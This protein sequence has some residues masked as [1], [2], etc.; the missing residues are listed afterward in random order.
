MTVFDR[1][2][3][4]SLIW[5]SQIPNA[6]SCEP[7][8]S[9]IRSDK[10]KAHDEYRFV[11]ADGD[12]RSRL[13]T[14]RQTLMLAFSYFQVMPEFLN[15]LFLFGQRALAIDL[16][17]SGF[18]HNTR[19]GEN[20]S[21]LTDETRSW[22]GADLQMC[23][24]L[25]SVEPSPSQI[26]WPWSIRHC[27][28]HHTFDVINIRSTWIMIKGDRKIAERIQSVT[29]G[30]GPAEF[31]SF[32]S[33]ICAFNA[34]LL[35]HIVLCDWSAEN[36][37]RYINF[38]ELTFHNLTDE[39]KIVNAE[40]PNVFKD[41][42]TF[43]GI[44]RSDT[45]ETLKPQKSRVF[46]WKSARSQKFKSIDNTTPAPLTNIYTNASGKRQPLP[47]GR[48]I[49]T[50]NSP[51]RV[52]KDYDEYG[53]QQYSFRDLQKVSEIEET[54]NECVLV[55]R[56]NINVVTQLKDHYASLMNDDDVPEEIRTCC[57]KPATRFEGRMDSIIKDLHL[58]I[59]RA[60]G[61]LRLLADRKVLV[62][63][64]PID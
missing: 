41:T 64:P 12:S 4:S 26:D 16:Y 13:R 58:Q 9:I 2:W 19:L 53:Q 49:D 47:P 63:N 34:S 21:N 10:R 27:A 30:Q 40:L 45:L 52:Q 50:P 20:S 22:S 18:H 59:L 33:I 6:C 32:D 37:Q 14:S 1:S 3:L 7:H 35:T 55:L 43:M 46:S 36:W 15:F 8:I 61:L 54:V 17:C 29:G 25:K 48:R 56:L 28:V 44:R 5:P 31:S 39:A 23:Y 60:E 38:L 11:F 51:K 62:N 42:D 24:T 57:K